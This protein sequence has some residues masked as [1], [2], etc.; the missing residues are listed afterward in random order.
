MGAPWRTATRTA[1]HRSARCRWLIRPSQYRR[2]R[3]C[4][5]IPFMKEVLPRQTARALLQRHAAVAEAGERRVQHLKAQVREHVPQLAAELGAERVYLFG[6]LAWGGAHAQTDVDLAVQG[7][8]PV[9]ANAFA[10]RALWCLDAP[11][12]IVALERASVSLRKRV[13]DHG[14]LLYDRMAKSS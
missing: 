4:S 2:M 6:S 9:R 5:K 8:D 7:L 14:E 12:D 10:A 13:L 3:F 1:T 11:V